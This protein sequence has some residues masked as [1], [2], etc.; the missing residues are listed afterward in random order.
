MPLRAAPYRREN[1]RRYRPWR[2][3]F[4]GRGWGRGSAWRREPEPEGP[5]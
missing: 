3:F 5:L 2:R 1:S 4:S